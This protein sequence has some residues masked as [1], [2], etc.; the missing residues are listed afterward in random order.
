[1]ARPTK[2]TPE[3]LEELCGQLKQGIPRKY[4]GAYVGIGKQTLYDWEQKGKHAAAKREEGATLTQNEQMYLDAA[5]QIDLASSYGVA[6]L[7]HQTLEAAGGEKAHLKRWQAYMTILERTHPADF[8]R[9]AAAEFIEPNKN[10]G[11]GRTIDV[12]K[13]DPDERAALRELLEKARRGDA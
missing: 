10:P 3:L 2:L 8:R 4:A 13:L 11:R 5:E 1:M 12:G 7:M 6:W 9:R